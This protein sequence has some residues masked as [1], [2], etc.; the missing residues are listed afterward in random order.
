[1]FF[2]APGAPALRAGWR[3]FI[4]LTLTIFPH[5]QRYLL[6]SWRSATGGRVHDGGGARS[7]RHSLRLPQALAAVTADGAVRM[8]GLGHRMLSLLGVGR[9]HV[10][11]RVQRA[12][13]AGH[14]W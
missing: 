14:G 1:M 13:A 5:N 12:D 7:L 11:N 10:A 8:G 3:G 9:V 6:A 2:V 4:S